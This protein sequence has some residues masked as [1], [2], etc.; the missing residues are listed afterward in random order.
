MVEDYTGMDTLAER[1][2]QVGGRVVPMLSPV[3]H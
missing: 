1:L 3:C 2:G